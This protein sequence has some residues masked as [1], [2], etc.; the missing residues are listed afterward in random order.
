[1]LGDSEA[2][3][4]ASDRMQKKIKDYAKI[5]GHIMR[6]HALIMQKFKQFIKLIIRPVQCIC[7][8]KTLSDLSNK[9]LIGKPLTDDNI[10][11]LSNDINQ[12]FLCPQ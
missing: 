6:K 7:M 9:L 12:A 11:C 8:G 10:K 5:F 1:M 2:T 4:W 3:S